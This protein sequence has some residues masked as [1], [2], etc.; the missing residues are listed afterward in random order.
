MKKAYIF[1]L[2]VV[3]ASMILMIGFMII[4]STKT[5]EI[6]DIPLPQASEGIIDTISKIRLSEICDRCNCSISVIE[7]YCSRGLIRNM[8]ATI[9]GSLGE[10]Y[11][12]GEDDEVI[13]EMFNMTSQKLFR[14]DIFSRDLSIDGRVIFSDQ[15]KAESS[16]VISARRMIIGYYE[17]RFTGEVTF[18][19]PYVLEVS[20]W[21]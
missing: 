2:D 18:W 12:R 15:G 14:K 17:N 3:F 10:M 19:G 7:D 16:E 1:M 5:R 21:K 4:S 8:D 9:A 11:H 6:D 20:V 13:G